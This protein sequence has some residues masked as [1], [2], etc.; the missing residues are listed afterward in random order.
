M[1]PVRAW[2]T[3]NLCLMAALP[4][5]VRAALPPAPTPG[6][7]VDA[8]V[9]TDDPT[10]SYALYLPSN[11]TAE[12]AWPIVYCFDPAARGR[13]PVERFRAAAELY[14]YII[15]GS[16]NSR[17]NL[18]EGIATVVNALLRDT[19]RRFR[20]D[21][22][23]KYAA[24]FSGGARV[25]CAVGTSVDFAGIIASGA[26]FSDK[27]VPAKLAPAF[28]GSAGREDFN[29]SEMQL[30]D[31]ALAAQHARHRLVI[32]EGSHEWLPEPQATEA[33]AWMELQ[34]MRSGL[35]PK[36]D[37][38][39]GTLLRQRLQAVAVLKNP[40]EAYEGYLAISADFAGLTDVSDPTGQAAT[41]KDTK[42]VR[43]YFKDEKRAAQQE[44]RWSEN[45]YGA[46]AAA[47]NWTPFQSRRDAASPQHRLP[48]AANSLGG[49]D[50]SVQPGFGS[51]ASM[52]EWSPADSDRADDTDRYA[53]LR[54]AVREVT[55]ESKTIVAA[56]RALNGAFGSS[57][58]QG[59]YLMEDK[60]YT[61]A[62]ECFEA[63]AIIRPESPASYVELTRAYA[64]L[65]NR[66]KARECLQNA[67]VKGLNDPERIKQ[68]QALLAP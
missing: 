58:E 15:V 52:E 55:R 47:K 37:A 20:L 50:D 5:G 16:N 67:I 61:A 22:H 13:R 32:F 44:Q 53:V 27:V 6:A 24:G 57:S 36:D 51:G 60:N 46:I 64:L 8:I 31:A 4:P 17:N 48:A 68:L 3:L 26:G 42:P 12:R 2:L 1:P 63:A 14:G 40:G 21:A 30:V 41:L 25:A 49:A 66:P 43:Q 56:R 38:L 65:G 28:F 18:R 62:A 39:I 7:I 11:Y 9:C 59:R 34:A 10:Q 45:L 29:Y 23:R 33:L 19:Y 54:D 35:R